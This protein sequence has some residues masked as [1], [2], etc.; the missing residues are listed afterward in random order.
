MQLELHVTPRQYK[1]L[2][3]ALSHEIDSLD[4]QI[5]RV[6]T[7]TIHNY[8]DCVF[9]EF[10]ILIDAKIDVQRVFEQV[11]NQTAMQEAM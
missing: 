6:S 3:D 5:D 1:L 9:R 11:K 8:Y 7:G 10:T 2:V 4:R